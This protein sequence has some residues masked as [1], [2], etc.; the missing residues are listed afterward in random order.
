MTKK[1]I[2]IIVI[3][4][5]SFLFMADS[6]PFPDRELGLYNNGQPLQLT[7]GQGFVPDQLVIELADESLKIAGDTPGQTSSSYN[8][9]L[10]A[11]GILRSKYNAEI[12]SIE[13]DRHTPFYIIET[14]SGCDIED[15]SEK[16]LLE[17]VV[18]SASL[19]YL[20]TITTLPNDPFFHFQYALKNT[21]QEYLPKLGLAGT[22]GADIKA[23]DGWDWSTG[24]KDSIIAIIDTGV[25]KAHEDLKTKIIAGYNFVDDNYDTDDNNGH[26]TFV[27]SIA[28]AET[29][30]A[31]GLA[32]VGWK[33]KIMPVKCVRSDGT[34]SYLAI[35][36]AI[37]Y[38]ANNGAQVINISLGG[39][40]NSII[41]EDACRF[42]FEKGCV[43]VA[44]AGNT[45]GAVLY[46][47]AYDDYCLAVAAVDAHDNTTTWSNYGP[48]VDVAAPGEYVFGAFYSPADPVNYK[49]YGWGS[50]TSFSAPMVSGAAALLVSYK[51]NFSNTA[52]MNLV[53]YTA[54][55]VN[56][57][58]HPGVDDYMGYGRLN[59]K[60]LLAPYD[61]N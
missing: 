23:A 52:I 57:S 55:D 17:P 22:A 3:N 42:A 15:L 14:Y 56:H 11:M 38:A 18:K 46:P 19:N 43:I 41:L 20:A 21:G 9:A 34:A 39:A 10:Q 5:I 51:P 28:A 13:K 29:N 47:A 24:A 53:K 4:A 59:L 31:I 8:Y 1:I 35:A 16:L 27:A 36:A 54:D 49:A 60:S 25:I 6:R 50:G 7:A 37:M 2:L 30:N 58:L 26:G 32:G 45:A 48:Q 40:G 61:L 44:A 12:K 33:A